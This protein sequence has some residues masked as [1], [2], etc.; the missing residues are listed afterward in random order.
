MTRFLLHGI[1]EFRQ[2]GYTF[3]ITGSKEG[4]YGWKLDLGRNASKRSP[5]LLLA[6]NGFERK[7]KLSGER[8][9]LNGIRKELDSTEDTL[10]QARKFN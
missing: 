1:L 5:Q 6:K 10:R 2:S 8:Y 4:H 3:K 7:M 9:T